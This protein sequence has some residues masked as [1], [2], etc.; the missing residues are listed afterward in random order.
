[1]QEM[2][3]LLSGK[4][5][6]TPAFQLLGCGHGVILQ[7]VFVCGKR[8]WKP[9][10]RAKENRRFGTL[11]WCFLNV[12][13]AN[14]SFIEGAPRIAVCLPRAASP[15]LN[16]THEPPRS[17]LWYLGGYNTP[18]VGEDS[19][20]DTVRYCHVDKWLQLGQTNRVDEYCN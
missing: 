5:V 7:T 2:R 1:M 8:S 3:L 6:Q 19:A 14:W 9:R 18:R 13:I 16:S 11:Q 12:Q 17:I 15:V 10:L 4:S 20:G